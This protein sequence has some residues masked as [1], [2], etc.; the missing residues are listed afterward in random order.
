[1]GCSETR[2]IASPVSNDNLNFTMQ[3]Q[4]SMYASILSENVSE[5]RRLL[6]EGFKINSQMSNFA[7]R[8][9]LHIA[10]EIGSTKVI[11][12]L[13]ENGADPNA[14]DPY[15]VTPVFLAVQYRNT[16]CAFLLENSGADIYLI[17]KTDKK[18][19][20][21]IPKGDETKYKKLFRKY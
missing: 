1:M 7:K 9:P 12:L 14:A 18:L 2:R 11:K 17:T 13:I 16:S 5:I 6:K 8:T 21:Y 15:G 19:A 20:D 3:N 10:S 4:F